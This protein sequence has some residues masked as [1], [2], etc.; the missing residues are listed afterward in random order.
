[1]DSNN[2]R[3]KDR[4]KVLL[5]KPNNVLFQKPELVSVNAPVA[6]MQVAFQNELNGILL[7]LGLPLLRQ[8]VLPIKDKDRREI[9]KCL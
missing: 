4:V 8:A 9:L 6:L 1:M 5:A 3:A 7:G 2:Q